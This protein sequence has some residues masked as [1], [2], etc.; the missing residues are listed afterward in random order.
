MRQWFNLPVLIAQVLDLLSPLTSMPRT[1]PSTH[2]WCA[3][4]RPAPVPR[5]QP[6]APPSPVFSSYDL[7]L[8]VLASTHP[9]ALS[10]K[11]YSQSNEFRESPQRDALL[12][13]GATSSTCDGHVFDEQVLHR[14]RTKASGKKVRSMPIWTRARTQTGE[15]ERSSAGRSPRTFG[16]E[17]LGA[18][19]SA[20][21]STTDDS[22]H[23]LAM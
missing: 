16:T 4:S 10:S 20:P 6:C 8:R 21:L 15:S 23:H 13:Q 11:S 18:N 14:I 2:K 19:S 22:R 5:P 1:S 7:R 12:R 3:C 9:C 17:S